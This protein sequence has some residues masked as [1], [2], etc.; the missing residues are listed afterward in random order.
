MGR[1][2]GYNDIINGKAY[3]EQAAGC[4][5]LEEDKTVF[6]FFFFDYTLIIVCSVPLTLV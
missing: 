6:F 1:C 5:F 2:S 4:V 3:C